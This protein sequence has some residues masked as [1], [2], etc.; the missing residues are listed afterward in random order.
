MAF[1]STCITPTSSAVPGFEPV[2]FRLET[3]NTTRLADKKGRIIP[4]VRA[5]WISDSEK[6]Q[7]TV[8]ARGDEDT[9]LM[10]LIKSGQSL[11]D[12]AKACNWLLPDGQPYKSKVTRTLKRLM[13]DKLVVPQA[14]RR[15]CLPTPARKR[16]FRR[17]KE[18]IR[19]ANRAGQNSWYG[20]IAEKTTTVPWFVPPVPKA[21]KMKEVPVPQPYHAVR[22]RP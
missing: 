17:M 12:L 10:S 14:R 3:V 19:R 8:R 22:P 1:C 4:T 21:S 13:E 9:S 11:G 6:D 18:E 2:N 20:C 16:P 5:V 15:T 7:Q